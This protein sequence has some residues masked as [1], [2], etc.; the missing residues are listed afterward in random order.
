[1][2]N[3]LYPKGKEAFLNGSINL[4]DDTIRVALIDLDVYSY[5]AAHQ[6]LTSVQAAIVGNPVNLAGKSIT[7][8]IFNA[9]TVTFSGVS[10]PTIEGLV[11][12]KAGATAAASP[13]IAFIDTVPR[14]LPITP[15]G[16]DVQ[17]LWD[18]GVN[19]IFAL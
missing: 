6:Y 16:G 2:A 19:K 11:I 10:G 18:T 14:G 13:L 3:V 17:I 5:N 7:N 9:A 8:G 15:N 12:Y 1:M 4:L